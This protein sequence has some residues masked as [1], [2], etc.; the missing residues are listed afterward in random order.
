MV[1]RNVVAGMGSHQLLGLL[2][3][4]GD[5][6]IHAGYWHLDT[7][8]HEERQVLLPAGS[9]YGSCVHRVY[10]NQLVQCETLQDGLMKHSSVDFC[11]GVHNGNALRMTC[12]PFRIDRPVERFMCGSR[13]LS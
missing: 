3:F 13:F 4:G 2:V 9:V 11:V 6:E 12:F 7:G 1:E 8:C 10:R 5:F